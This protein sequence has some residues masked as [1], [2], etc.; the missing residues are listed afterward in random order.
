MSFSCIEAVSVS[1]CAWPIMCVTQ[2]GMYTTCGAAAWCCQHICHML[3][4]AVSTSATCS[5]VLSAHLPHAPWCCQHICHMLAGG[6]LAGTGNR[7]LAVTSMHTLP[8][9]KSR[10]LQ[11]MCC[12][13]W[14]H[15]YS[16]PRHGG[17]AGPCRCLSALLANT[18]AAECWQALACSPASSQYT[19]AVTHVLCSVTTSPG[20][21]WCLG[22]GAAWGHAA[23]MLAA[24]CYGGS[25]Q[26]SLGPD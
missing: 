23:S 1:D 25:G 21:G 18:L 11:H 19:P 24:C 26:T 4:G 22:V 9:G 14:S 7:A 2:D 13:Q 12:V 8:T 10:Q 17:G 6:M 15:P 20:W 16:A 5:L 3:V